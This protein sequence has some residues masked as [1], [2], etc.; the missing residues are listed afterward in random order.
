MLSACASAPDAAK[1][2]KPV[3]PQ[4]TEQ[5]KSEQS[6]G[7]QASNQ[8]FTQVINPVASVQSD[9]PR[10]YSLFTL[11]MNQVKQRSSAMVRRDNGL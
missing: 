9:K 1:P 3:K 6:F 2:N 5:I 7:K 10:D 8:Q 4:P 11:Q